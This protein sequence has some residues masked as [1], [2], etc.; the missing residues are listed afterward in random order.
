MGL[1]L[2]ARGQISHTFWWVR[3]SL[4][5]CW[6]WHSLCPGS[7]GLSVL[8]QP[9]ASLPGPV[10]VSLRPGSELL[11]PRPPPPESSPSNPTTPTSPHLLGQTEKLVVEDRQRPFSLLEKSPSWAAEHRLEE[12]KSWLTNGFDIFECPPPK[13]DNEV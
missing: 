7:Y 10:L 2:S 13:T 12:K 9:F 5:G 6:C 11:S 1:C 8:T 4:Q 3:V